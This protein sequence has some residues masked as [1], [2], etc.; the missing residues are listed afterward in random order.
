M[1]LTAACLFPATTRKD[2][3]KNPPTDFFITTNKTDCFIIM[4]S[5]QQNGGYWFRLMWN[6]MKKRSLL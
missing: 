5:K 4:T 2:W 6:P 3:Y 1:H